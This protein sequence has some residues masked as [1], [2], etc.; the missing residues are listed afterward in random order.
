MNGKTTYIKKVA[1]ACIYCTTWQMNDGTKTKSTSCT[2]P[3]YAKPDIGSAHFDG[4][5]VYGAC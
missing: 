3:T 1:E 5:A 4:G 2:M